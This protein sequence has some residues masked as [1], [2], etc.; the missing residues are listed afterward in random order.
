MSSVIRSAKCPKCGYEEAYEEVY[1][2]SGD[3]YLFCER[4]GYSIFN[5]EES[6]G[7]GAY[8]LRFKGVWAIRVGSFKDEEEWKHMVEWAKRNKSK[9]AFFNISIKE[10]GRWSRI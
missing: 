2:R 5:G 10:N 3:V 1:C 7:F 9:I 8:K 6:G 4:C